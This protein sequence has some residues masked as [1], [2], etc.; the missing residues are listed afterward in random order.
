ME[1]NRR[2]PLDLGIPVHGFT[3]STEIAKGSLI[4]FPK[5]LTENSSSGRFGSIA[6]GDFHQIAGE[7]GKFLIFNT[8]WPQESYSATIRMKLESPLAIDIFSFSGKNEEFNKRLEDYLL[9][10]LQIFEE[11]IRKDT[12]YMAF[13]PGSEATSKL[14]GR[15]GI[16][17]KLFRGNM[18]NLF[19]LSIILGVLLLLLLQSMGLGSIAPFVMIAMLLSIVLSA[20]K[21]L[22]IRSD[23]RIT[24]K[25][26]D[27][28]IIECKLDSSI[29]PTFFKDRESSL[30]ALKRKLYETMTYEKRYLNHTEVAALF[31]GAGIPAV[32]GQV[33]VKRINIFEIVKRAAKRFEM[34]IPAIVVT[35]NPKPNA[36]ATGF[37]KRLA[38]MLITFG[39]LVQLE[40]KEIELVVGHELSHLRFGDPA[41]LFT[42]IISEYLLRVYVFL[43]YMVTLPWILPIFYLMFIF[44]LIFFF[45]KFL[46]ARADLEAAYILRDP[47]T[48]A[49]SLKKI[50]FK[51][52]LL[53]SNFIE[54]KQTSFGDWLA[55]DPH[56][57]LGFRIRRMENLDLNDVPKHTLLRSISDVFRGISSSRK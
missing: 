7:H 1:N 10:S 44:W 55:F 34:P 46:E 6:A 2:S 18:L 5:F 14:G 38:T 32:P 51:R 12:I 54:G 37:S 29:V 22:A 8:V 50:G 56:P 36:A 39:L 42:I 11:A 23:W 48:M 3:L 28:V 43:P 19:L 13:V 49:N 57:P 20:G 52:L 33:V 26:T 4:S 41:I 9:L 17:E 40:E 21:I 45:G 31:T 25:N 53:D 47:Q 16:S 30:S 15:S 35:K 24:E 27:V